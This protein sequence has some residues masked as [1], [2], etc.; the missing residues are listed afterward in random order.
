MKS[1]NN[2]NELKLKYFEYFY[3]NYY[4]NLIDLFPLVRVMSQ[5]CCG[6]SR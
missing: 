4:N 5:T 6:C 1:N 3:K 2:P